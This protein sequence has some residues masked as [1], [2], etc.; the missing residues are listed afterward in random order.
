SVGWM[1]KGNLTSA[2]REEEQERW[3]DT[4]LLIIKNNRTPPGSNGK[5]FHHVSGTMV[6]VFPVAT[7]KCSVIF[8]N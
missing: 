7:W 2:F 8:D 6:E 3:L 5:H 4:V 1:K